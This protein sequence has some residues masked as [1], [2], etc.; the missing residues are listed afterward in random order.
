MEG[1][2][3]QAGAAPCGNEWADLQAARDAVEG[4]RPIVEGGRDLLFDSL[5]GPRL[6]PTDQEAYC[7]ASLLDIEAERLRDAVRL[8]TECIEA[9]RG[10]REDGGVALGAPSEAAAVDSSLLGVPEGVRLAML[11]AEA[12][13]CGLVEDDAAADPLEIPADMLAEMGVV[14]DEVGQ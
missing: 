8:L 10:R 4:A 11:R 3:G 14:P 6:R 1:N 9:R 12:Q 5:G 7:I 2:E 13:E